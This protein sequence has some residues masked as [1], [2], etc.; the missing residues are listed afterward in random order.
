MQRSRSERMWHGRELGCG[1]NF[2]CMERGEKWR[3][4]FAPFSL[5]NTQIGLKAK[6]N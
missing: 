1:A 4:F 5:S 6:S 3:D 2:V